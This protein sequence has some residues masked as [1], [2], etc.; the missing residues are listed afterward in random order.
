MIPI[1]A[2]MKKENTEGVQ[3]CPWKKQDSKGGWLHTL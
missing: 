2:Y 3:V 1:P